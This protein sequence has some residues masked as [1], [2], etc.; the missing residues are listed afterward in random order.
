MCNGGTS[1]VNTTVEHVQPL[2]DDGFY[3]SET[4]PYEAYQC[5]EAGAQ[6]VGGEVG[7]TSGGAY[8]SG[9]RHGLQCHA[10]PLG[11][12][13]P[14]GGECQ[15]C[16]SSGQSPILPLACIAGC[17]GLLLIYKLSTGK[18]ERA[19]SK[20]AILGM[21][22][23]LLT[24]TQMFSI[25]VS[26]SVRRSSSFRHTFQ[27]MEIFAFDL[28]TTTFSSCHFGHDSMGPKYLPGLFMPVVIIGVMMTFWAV[29]QILAHL[30]PQCEAMKM[31]QSINA[32]GMVLMSLYICVCKAVFNIF[33]C[34][35]NPSAPDTLRS[36]DGFLCFGDEVQ[37]MIPAAILGAL[38]YVVVLNS[39]YIWVIVK[40]PSKYQDSASFRLRA[41]FL[42]YKWHPERWFWGILF[43]TRNLICSLIPSLTTDGSVQVL[44]MFVVMFTYFLASASCNPW[45]DELSNTHDLTM[46]GALLMT[47]VV[48]QALQV[49][50]TMGS[51]WF[52]M[53]EA[54]SS[55]L[56]FAAAAGCGGMLL[57]HLVQELVLFREKRLS[58]PSSSEDLPNLMKSPTGQGSKGFGDFSGGIDG[59]RKLRARMSLSSTDEKVNDIYSTLTALSSWNGDDTLLEIV[60]Q[61][62]EELPTSD[63]RRLQWGMGIIGYHVLGDRSRKPSGIVLAPA[64]CR[65]SRASTRGLPSVVPE[66]VGELAEV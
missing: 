31:D 27:W 13:A 38:I 61:L 9:G 24:N 44:S 54:A 10:C 2:V 23:I 42:L 29:S 33:E 35:Q 43:L 55:A 58:S 30:S 59:S 62:E 4:S 7:G 56:F 49:P 16:G 34:R 12:R 15:D 36:H 22:S 5:F 66:V 50:S 64:A 32:L 48:S 45:R 17:F 3:V 63:L 21:M 41:H 52:A 53:L 57:K 18:Q 65:N 39:V 40:A 19:S 1:S 51:G 25:I 8:C 37:D 28:D 26:F 11:Q 60:K 6:C 14:P 47:L 46:V 20:T